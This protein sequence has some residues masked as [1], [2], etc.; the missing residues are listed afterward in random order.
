MDRETWWSASLRLVVL[1]AGEP[2]DEAESVVLVRAPE[3]DW[4]A[5][6]N[7]ALEVG[8]GMEHAYANPDGDEVSWRLRAVHTLDELGA[9]VEDGR[10]VYFVSRPAASGARPADLQPE[11]DR[12]AQSGV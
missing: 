7:R 4:D 12:P 5:A 1:V 9:A 6:F 2:S 10:E 8:R 3:A 11:K